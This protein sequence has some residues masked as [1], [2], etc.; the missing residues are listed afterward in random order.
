MLIALSFFMYASV[1]PAQRILRRYP[2]SKRMQ[3]AAARDAI[4]AMRSSKRSSEE[5]V[6]LVNEVFCRE[7]VKVT[8][9]EG[10]DESEVEFYRQILSQSRP[11]FSAPPKVCWDAAA[12]D[13]DDG[14]W[15]EEDDG[16][17]TDAPLCVEERDFDDKSQL[18]A[19]FDDTFT[20]EA[21][22]KLFLKATKPKKRQEE[23]QVEAT[24][25]LSAVKGHNNNNNDDDS[26]DDDFH[27]KSV[28]NVVDDLETAY[29]S[30]D[31]LEIMKKGLKAKAPPLRQRSQRNRLEASSEISEPPTPPSRRQTQE[32]TKHLFKKAG[33]LDISPGKQRL[34]GVTPSRRPREHKILIS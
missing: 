2:K 33:V 23:P 29:P 14:F 11:V 5:A 7:P 21:P 24:K 19:D 4:R 15:E 9:R 34:R 10:M 32:S 28:H 6:E 1:S 8:V 31:D 26:D 18:T 22:Q 12:D 3:E 20:V 16:A 13:D 27:E 17:D 25:K 30:D